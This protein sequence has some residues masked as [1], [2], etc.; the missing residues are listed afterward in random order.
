MTRLPVSES[1]VIAFRKFNE[2]LKHPGVWESNEGATSATDSSR[3]NLASLYRPPFQLLFQ[4]FFEKA[5]SATSVQ[6]KWLMVNLQSNSEFSS[7]MVVFLLWSFY[8]RFIIIFVFYLTH[9]WCIC[10]YFV[11]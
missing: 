7:H 10:L 11:N 3:D 6:D 8:F 9:F 1:G 4:G 5:K 2:E